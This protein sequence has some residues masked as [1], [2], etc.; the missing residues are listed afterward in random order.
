MAFRSRTFRRDRNTTGAWWEKALGFPGR[1][2]RLAAIALPNVAIETLVTPA[3]LLN[4]SSVD[5]IAL[6]KRELIEGLWG[7]SSLAVLNADDA[8]VAAMASVA[9]GRGVFLGGE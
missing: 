7:P 8:R 1:R 6:A 9:P 5:E 4:F 3:H 2:N